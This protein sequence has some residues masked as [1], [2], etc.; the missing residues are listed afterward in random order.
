MLEVW[1]AADVARM[2][3]VPQETVIAEMISGHMPGNTIAGE[4]RVRATALVDWL[5]GAYGERARS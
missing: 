2:L 5:D 4:W 3:G 1:T